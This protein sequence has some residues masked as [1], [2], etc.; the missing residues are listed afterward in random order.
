MLNG[1]NQN[2]G[3]KGDKNFLGEV[4]SSVLFVEV[5]DSV[6]GYDSLI[7]TGSAS[8]RNL[9]L[10]GDSNMIDGKKMELTADLVT[11]KNEPVGRVVLYVVKKDVQS[12]SAL[13]AFTTEDD[14]KLRQFFKVK[15]YCII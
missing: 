14:L 9:C 2:G 3:L 12:V 6:V 13:A 11:K 5:W 4:D 7:G 1:E 10:S 8:I 15:D